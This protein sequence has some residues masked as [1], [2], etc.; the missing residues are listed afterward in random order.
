VDVTDAALKCGPC[1]VCGASQNNADSVS[2][3]PCENCRQI[4]CFR[5]ADT[6]VYGSLPDFQHFVSGPFRSQTRSHHLNR[7]CCPFCKTM[8]W[9]K[10]WGG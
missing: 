4:I 7:D 9:M 6:G 8:N 1:V 10:K 5:C 2:R 3:M